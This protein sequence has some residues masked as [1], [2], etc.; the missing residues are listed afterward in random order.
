MVRTSR[1]VAVVDF[2]ESDYRYKSVGT[3]MPHDVRL[4]PISYTE[5]KFLHNR[6]L[7]PLRIQ[8]YELETIFFTSR[9]HGG[10]DRDN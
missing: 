3:E 7:N 4:V 6:V 10:L 8:Y 1:H 5:G 2:L 9:E